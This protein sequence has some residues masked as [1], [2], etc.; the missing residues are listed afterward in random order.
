M[1]LETE[2]INVLAHLPGREVDP[3]E[4][5]DGRDRAD[6][7]PDPEEPAPPHRT[8]THSGSGRGV[9]NLTRYSRGGASQS[10]DHRVL[11]SHI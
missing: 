9:E 4:A 2:F 7:R 6:R 5:H 10:L 1:D 8:V 3:V 11:M